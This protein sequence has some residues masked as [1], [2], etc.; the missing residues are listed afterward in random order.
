MSHSVAEV[1]EDTRRIYSSWPGADLADRNDLLRQLKS[2]LSELW[3]YSG[4]EALALRRNI[5]T[6]IDEA[7]RPRRRHVS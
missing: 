1:D 2:M 6:F 7:E 5:R 3:D 4:N